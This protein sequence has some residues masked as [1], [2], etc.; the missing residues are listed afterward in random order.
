MK[1][2]QDQIQA[3]KRLECLAD[4]D[5]EGEKT[6]DGLIDMVRYKALYFTGESNDLEVLVNLFEEIEKCNIQRKN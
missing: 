1:L 3:F 4:Y 5:I 2:T 6:P